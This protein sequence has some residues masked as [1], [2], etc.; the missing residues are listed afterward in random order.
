VDALRRELAGR[1]GG[2]GASITVRDE[3][4]PAADAPA[5]ADTPEL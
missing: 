4:P 1:F 5:P 2:C 3:R